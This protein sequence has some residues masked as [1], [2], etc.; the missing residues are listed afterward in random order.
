MVIKQSKR[1]IRTIFD[2][3]FF[4]F[5]A[6]V[7]SS[8]GAGTSSLSP[9]TSNNDTVLPTDKFSEEDVAEVVKLGFTRHQA[10]AELRAA[11]GNKTQ[12]MAALFAKSLKY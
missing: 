12:A 2:D 10:I 9:T 8:S 11:S 3:F 7:A 6:G 1:F 4:F 5:S